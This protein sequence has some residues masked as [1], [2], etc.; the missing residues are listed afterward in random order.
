VIVQSTRKA[1]RAKNR[2]HGD[3]VAFTM[4]R[5]RG[6][7]LSGLSPVTFFVEHRKTEKRKMGMK[8]IDFKIAS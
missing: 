7:H 8:M 1:F 6:S 4:D 3:C 5:S 2:S